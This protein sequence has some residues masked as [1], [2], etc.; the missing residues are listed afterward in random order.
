MKLAI[1]GRGAVAQ[2]LVQALPT[3]DV[4]LGVRTPQAVQEAE[5]AQA[6]AEADAVILATPWGAMEDVAAALRVHV[7]GKPVIDATNPLGMTDNGLG[8]VSGPDRSGGEALQ[9][10]LPEAHVV[11]CFNQIG[12]EFIAD[13]GQLGAKPVMFAAGD[14]EAAR[15]VALSLAEDAGFE[16]IS[17]G[18][19]VNARHLEHMAML[20]IWNAL[21]GELGRR[22]GFALSHQGMR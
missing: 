10:A 12:A 16:A 13:A 7:A 4:M 6:A 21:R 20:W 9:A 19:L 8:L 17:A 18:A 2:A 14:N 5:V 3:H 1:I 15:A 11:K 22:F